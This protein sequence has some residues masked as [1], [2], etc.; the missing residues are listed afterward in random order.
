MDFNRTLAYTGIGVY[1]MII[2]AWIYKFVAEPLVSLPE[3]P[4]SH[5]DVTIEI[6]DPATRAAFLLGWLA[7]WTLPCGANFPTFL[8]IDRICESTYPDHPNMSNLTAA[9]CIDG[10]TRGASFEMIGQSASCELQHLTSDG[11]TMI[12]TAVILNAIAVVSWVAW[13]N[14]W[15]VDNDEQNTLAIRSA[16]ILTNIALIII[17]GLVFTAMA[18][19][20]LDSMPKTL[21]SHPWDNPNQTAC[22]LDINHHDIT[23]C[24]AALHQGLTHSPLGQHCEYNLVVPRNFSDPCGN[25]CPEENGLAYG[26]TMAMAISLTICEL[27]P[28]NPKVDA[29]I[30]VILPMLAVGLMVGLEC[31]PPS[32]FMALK[33]KLC[34]SMDESM[35]SLST[36]FRARFFSSEDANPRGHSDDSRTALLSSN[37]T[38]YDGRLGSQDGIQ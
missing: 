19:S 4:P 27:T 9:A 21:R 22:H 18:G 7:D 26:E 12:T 30:N 6:D 11:V 1:A 29:F 8:P 5:Q 20:I 16:I 32:Q 3:A 23:S 37:P 2:V 14:R 38:Y 28:F 25:T 35:Q 13:F 36:R 10:A 24:M 34:L 33:Q 31:L 15:Y 17:E